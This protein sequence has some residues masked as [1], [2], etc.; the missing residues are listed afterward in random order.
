V[1]ARWVIRKDA[2]SGVKSRL[3]AWL[4]GLNGNDERFIAA[5]APEEAARLGMTTAEMTDYLRGM[6][7][8]LGPAELEG[9]RIFLSEIEKRV[10]AHVFDPQPIAPKTNHRENRVD[11][12]GARRLLSELP[13]GELL[14]QAHAVRMARFPEGRVTYVRDTNPNYTNICTTNCRFCAFC[15]DKHDDDAYVLSPD[16]LAAKV[17]TAAA[18]GATTVLLQGG[19][20]PEIGLEDWRAYIREIRARCPE[21]H[22]H[23]FSPPE[24]LDMAVKESRSPREILDVLKREGIDTMP[25]GGAEILVDEVRERIAPGKCPSNTWLDIM[26]EAHDVGIRTTATMMFGHLETDDHIVAHLMKLR[27]LQDRTGGF[28]AFIPWSFKPGNSRLSARV[29]VPAHPAK[30]LRILAT[31]RIV[32]DNFAHI[33]SSWFSESERAGML[34]L[35][36]GADD[37]GGILVEENVLK[38]SGYVRQTTEERVRELI[39]RSGFTP[40]LR[41]SRYRIIETFDDMESEPS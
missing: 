20:N 30:Y 17:K 28:N 13:L 6:K 23:P 5:C 39:L 14:K 21:I 34:G 1:F 26:A 25:G 40:A 12:D 37:F 32:L 27:A 22:I 10:P 15:R 29:S 24:I 31:A 7:R 4:D 36:A 41:D 35:I 11:A 33:Q 18:K 2:P 3:R 16:T 9:Q 8:I 19:L 38:T